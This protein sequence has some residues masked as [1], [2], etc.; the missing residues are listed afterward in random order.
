[1][2][3]GLSS[4][5]GSRRAWLQARRAGLVTHSE[6]PLNAELRPDAL[7]GDVTPTEEFFRRN[8]F[9]IPELTEATWRLR[10]GG[11]VRR[12][13][14]LTLADLTRLGRESAAVTLECAGNGRTLFSPQPSGEP[15]GLGA[16]SS[17][18][19]TGVP[20]ADVLE[21]AGIEPQA[22]EIVFR[23]ADQGHLDGIKERIRFERSLSVADALAADGLLAYQMNGAPLPARHGFPLRLVVPGWYAVASV[24]WLTEIDVTDEPFTGFFQDEHY[25][26]EWQRSDRLVRE[27]VRLQRVRSLITEPADGSRLAAGDLTVSG[28][29]WSG[30]APVVRVA[31][32][33]G[34]DPW[35]DARLLDRERPSGWQRWSL[36]VP[37]TP[38]G[39]TRIRARAFDA[40]GHAQPAEPEWNP[41]GY[42][43]NFVHEIT[44]TVG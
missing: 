39:A 36:T 24:K 3:S 21:L 30:A 11:M 28:L 35:R 14:T 27:P 1:V 16:V 25:V 13:L 2:V 15:W 12:P 31:V 26:F 5:L 4:E 29:A 7:G 44:V 32:A 19:W 37:W 34:G 17:A 10:V 6:R 43:G 33:I 41:R 38:A 18:R 42:G 20:L 40:A 9:P 23:G 8:H 22:R